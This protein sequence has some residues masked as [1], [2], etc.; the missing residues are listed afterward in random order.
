MKRG[1]PA[2]VIETCPVCAAKFSAGSQPNPKTGTGM[3]KVCPNG[4][5]TG[6][7]RL[8]EERRV[9]EAMGEVDNVDMVAEKRRAASSA[10]SV[11]LRSMV[12][13]Y[14]AA[15]ER[16]PDRSKAKAMLEGVFQNPVAIAVQILE[17]QS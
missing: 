1:S 16:F 6:I 3:G 14:N 2:Y 4:H 10:E 13:A 7:H 5:W 11:A 9:R 8:K 12:E 17:G 15:A